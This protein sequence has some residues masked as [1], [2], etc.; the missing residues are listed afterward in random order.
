MKGG[1]VKHMEPD[2]KDSRVEELIKEQ[3]WND[4][5][6]S[7]REW[8]APDIAELLLHLKRRDRVLVFRLLPRPLSSE[9]FSYLESRQQ[10]EL[11][12]DMTDEEMRQLLANL[13][14]DD[15]TQFLEELPGQ[16]VQ[17]LLN[18]L[19]HE[20]R[21]ETLQ[22]LGYPEESVGRLMTP[23]Y[24]AIR[25]EWTI[26]QALQHIRTKGKP[27]FDT[28]LIAERKRFRL[29]PEGQLL[30]MSF[31][32]Y[33]E[34]LKQSKLSE[35]PEKVGMVIRVDE[36]IARAAEEFLKEYGMESEIE[37]YKWEF[38]LI[39][40]DKVVNG[41]CM[42]GGKV[43]VY[44]GLLP[45]ARD[46]IGLAVSMGH[47]VAHAIAKHGN[48]RVSQGLLTQLG[49]VSLSIALSREPAITQQIFMA[50]Y[51]V[52]AQVGVLLPYSRLHEREADRIGLILMARAGYDPREAVSFWER[53]NE[54]AKGRRPPEFLSTHPALEARIREIQSFIPEA[55]TY[56]R[57]E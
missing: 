14:P 53:M 33:G 38:R 44:T 3:R 50:A 23:D 32:Q 28:V 1:I 35:D 9:V 29:I 55:M 7:M 37:H 24:V 26:E 51:G 5:R 40:D 4:L 20:D 43:A 17:K 47:E 45:I 27:K 39:E 34:V 15:R 16:A 18:L 19:S 57:S 30:S 8:P 56:Y 12:R 48:E 2:S 52:G 22:L 11:L 36:K 31:Q 6:E 41:W 54:E 46:E 49:A 25:P 21:R 10:D 13:S 42:P